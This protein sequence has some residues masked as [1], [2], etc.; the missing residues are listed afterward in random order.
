MQ[1]HLA[2]NQAID[3][4]AAHADELAAGHRVCSAAESK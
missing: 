2:Q 3:D 4:S 1:S